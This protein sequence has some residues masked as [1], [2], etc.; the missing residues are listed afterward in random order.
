MV[1]LPGS[2]TNHPMADRPVRVKHS[3]PLLHAAPRRGPATHRQLFRTRSE[4]NGL[5]SCEKSEQ[6]E[7]VVPPCLNATHASFFL[8]LITIN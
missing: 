3:D 7:A 4:T 8:N 2:R 5:A 1:A 6:M